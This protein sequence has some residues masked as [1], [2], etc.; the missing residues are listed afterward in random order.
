MALA[1]CGR[2]R[3]DALDVC[4]SSIADNLPYA[5]GTGTSED[6][7]QLCSPMQLSQLA[8]RPSDHDSSFVVTHDID[9]AGVPFAG[10]GTRTAPFTGRFDGNGRTISN[11]EITG[12]PG[13]PAGFFNVAQAAR[14]ENLRLD[15]V[16]V[17]GTVS[18]GA[19][20][21]E[22]GDAQFRNTV[23]N[24]GE[25]GGDTDVG[26]L[27]GFVSS[28]LFLGGSFDGRVSGSTE[29]IGG[30][31]GEA[32]EGIFL[33]I[34]ATVD[35]DA[36]LASEVGGMVGT[37]GSQPVIVQNVVIQGNV[38]GDE[39]V[40]G[41][42]GSN[43]D[44]SLIYRSRFSGTIRGNTG[45][46]GVAGNNYDS[47]FEVYS[48]SVAAQITG[49]NAVGGL[50]GRHDYRT[51][52]VDSYFTGTL[53]GVGAGQRA[54][55]GFF[56]AAG[57]YGWVDRSY[58][59]VTIDSQADTVGGFIGY[60]DYWSDRSDEYDIARSFAVAHVTGSSPTAS[61]SPWVGQNA[62]SV[63]LVGAGSYSWSGA[64][65]VN[66]GGG[67]CGA[68]G[69]SVATVA[70]LRSPSSPPLSSWDFEGVW[71]AQSGAFPTLRLE[72]RWA[73]VVTNSCPS[74]AIVGNLYDCGVT[75]SDLD[76][77]EVQV[78]AL[79]DQHSCAWI[80]ARAFSLRGTPG[81][82]DPN[83]SCT[84]AFSVTDGPH[85]TPVQTIVVD[86]YAGVVMEPSNGNGAF[87]FP[88]QPTVGSPG[89]TQ[90]F[91][92]TNRESV[93]ATGLAVSGL[94]AGDFLFAGGAYPGTGG[95]CGTSL[96]PGATCTVAIT[97]APTV[98]GSVNTAIDIRF[99]TTRAPASYP[100]TLYGNGG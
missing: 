75:I 36:P 45:V 80:A 11:V 48:T 84:V 46:G 71:Q 95:T 61:I 41:L 99:T 23:V 34:D 51:R 96:A 1:G 5:A 98:V 37:D 35:V 18:V 69:S 32:W 63:P 79:E 17:L 53:T 76:P 28:C 21:G 9:L 44:G 39:G 25:I 77:N 68:A 16:T 6:P 15:G 88:G 83:A 42:V 100:F 20:V 90:V 64:S 81:P 55:G 70:E 58:V 38:V 65:C 91:T 86:I 87:F 72:Q 7:F 82:T 2:Y 30:I 66:L 24:A 94:P 57:Y 29:S 59:D 47:P 3:F 31:V 33:D 13:E 26:G 43:N 97:Y 67:G 50:S 4:P 19:A 89:V 22:C 8:L 93:T 85:T 54:F 14:I 74:T 73:P 10:I 52:F 49:N 78:I 27:T 60:I 12:A 56:G 92:L 40:G 62:D